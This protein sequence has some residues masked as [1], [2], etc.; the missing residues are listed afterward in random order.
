MRAA[1][2]FLLVC[3]WF[4]PAASLAGRIE[5]IADASPAAERG[6]WG[7]RVID[8]ESGAVIYQHNARKLFIPASNVKL[9]TT[10]LALVRLG[11]DHRF[12]TV[13]RAASK[14]NENGVL[15]GNLSL[16]GGGDPTLSARKIPY[17]K[18]RI[19]GDALAPLKALASQIVAAGVR[20][21]DGDIIGDD[22]AFVW[23][24]YPEGWALDD[25]TFE[26]GAPVSA[27]TLHDNAFRLSVIAGKKAGSPGRIILNPPVEYYLIR[28]HVTTVAR[29]EARIWV[30]WP[31]GSRE[32]HVWGQ[33]KPRAGRAKLLAVRDPAHYA[34]W[35]LARELRERGV[36][37][38]GSIRARHRWMHEVTDFTQ[39]EPPAKPVGVVLAERTSPPLFELLKV[40]NKVS[41][42]LHAEIMLREVGRVRR[43]IGS[44]AAGLAELADFLEE[45]GVA[46]EEYHLEDGSGLSRMDL[47]SPAATVK[48]LN[49]MYLSTERDGWLEILAIGG[50]DGTLEYRFRKGGAKGRVIGK[51]GTLT[52]ASAL[53]GYLDARSGRTFAF[54]LMINNYNTRAAPARQFLDAVVK[55]L[56]EQ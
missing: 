56:L 28:N 25:A 12:R 32:I 14:P 15:R 31:P 7:A 54:S 46:P 1:L 36:T 18:G 47:L 10:A 26:Y 42:N 37:I 40:I 4:L 45:A 27:L 39:A 17:E 48:L 11:P 51:T 13:V 19:R 52:G 9:Y 41:Q 50:E 3:P 5:A 29:G 20:E 8:L 24:P 38:R 23:E 2:L 35:V 30:E 53:S 21:I 6:F 44:R 16:V 55:L 22:T 43:H 49:H 33:V 34:A